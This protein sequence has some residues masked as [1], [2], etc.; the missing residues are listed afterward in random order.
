MNTKTCGTC[1]HYKDGFCTY[2]DDPFEVKKDDVFCDDRFF[3]PKKLTNGDVIRQM[4]NEELAELFALSFMCDTCLLKDVECVGDGATERTYAYCHDKQL[5]WLNTPV[6][7]E[8][9]NV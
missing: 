7:S 2:G 1:T 4:S 5:A 8:V 9:K 3:E 6:K